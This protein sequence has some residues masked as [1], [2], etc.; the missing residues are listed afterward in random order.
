MDR[1]LR[2]GLFPNVPSDGGM[3]APTVDEVRDMTTLISDR[4]GDSPYD[5]IIEGV[6][7]THD[8]AKVVEQV[9]SCAEAGCHLVGRVAMGR[10]RD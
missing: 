7:A 3:R 5:M 6:S 4:K 2:Y 10:V 1:A 9:C 8:R